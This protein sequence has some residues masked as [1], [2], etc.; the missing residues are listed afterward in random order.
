MV[1][2]A[3]DVYHDVD[4]KRNYR[5]VYQMYFVKVSHEKE[6][7]NFRQLEQH[8]LFLYN[9]IYIWYFLIRSD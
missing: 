8:D 4:K 1:C 5:S 3:W 7:F 2:L 6:Y 9:H